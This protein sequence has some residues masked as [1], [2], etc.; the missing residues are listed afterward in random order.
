ME[1]GD[2]YHRSSR[3][4][5]HPFLHAL[6]NL[7]F[8]FANITVELPW[9]T[10][11]AIIIFFCFYYPIGLYRNAEPTGEVHVRGIQFF[12]FVLAFLLFTTTFTNM[13]I[14]G[15]ADAETGAN[16]ANVLFSLSL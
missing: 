3:A 8:M 1:T 14:A 11:M 10:L 6:T 16:L 4:S 9:N 2:P 7:A 12:L 13:M 5:L 15:A